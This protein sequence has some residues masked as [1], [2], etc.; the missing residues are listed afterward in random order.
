MST[1]LIFFSIF[2]PFFI[3]ILFSFS[4]DSGWK[5]LSEQ[6]KTKD[7]FYGRTVKNITACFK[8]NI[9]CSG[10]LNIGVDDQHMHLSMNPFFKLFT[11]N[12]LIPIEDVSFSIEKK[13]FIFKFKIEFK[14]YPDVFVC[15][16]KKNAQK[17]GMEI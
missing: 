1:E 3:F 10:I 7:K 12:L 8:D 11:P 5:N 15:I 13:N 16:T 17:L 14:M 2:I 6:Y 4:K 9:H